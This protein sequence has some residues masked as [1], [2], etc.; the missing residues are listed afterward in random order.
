DISTEQLS[1]LSDETRALIGQLRAN[2]DVKKVTIHAYVSPS[3]PSEFTSVKHSLLST[4]E[5][6]RALGRGKIVVQIHEIPNYGPEA[7]IAA[8]NFGITPQAQYVTERG[9]TSEQ[10]FFLGV[11]V[12]SGLDNVVTPF[13][14][15]GIPVEYELVRSI[16]TVAGERRKRV[17]IVETGLRM[18]GAGGSRADEWPLVTELRKQYDVTSVDPAQP[19]RGRYDALLVVQPTMLSPDAFDNVLDAIRGG[20]PTAVLEDPFPYFFS[21]GVPGTGQPKQS[22]AG[23]FGGM[24]SMPQQ[25]PKGDP[26][27]LW[28]LLG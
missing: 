16:M 19:I 18:V 11:A 10:E 9:E 28:R 25:E 6:L 20:T 23:G 7:A 3:V 13:L 22:S 26:Q 24:F 5:E 17:G 15:R 27:L 4:L 12:T 2:D 14:N 1:S 21:E 8:K